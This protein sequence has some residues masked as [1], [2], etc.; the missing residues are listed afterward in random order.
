MGKPPPS[1]PVVSAGNSQNDHLSE[2]ISNFPEPV[3]K[4]WCGGMEK[5]SIGDMMALID[6]INEQNIELEDI[7]LEGVDKDIEDQEKAADERYNNFEAEQLRLDPDGWKEDI[8]SGGSRLDTTLQS[9]LV[10]ERMI[11]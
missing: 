3:V 1:R 4:T 7:D 9:L 8:L 6:D 11:C 2:I 10:R 5:E